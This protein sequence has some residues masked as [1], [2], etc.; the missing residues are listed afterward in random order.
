MADLESNDRYKNSAIRKKRIHHPMPEKKVTKIKQ[1]VSSIRRKT[2]SGTTAIVRRTQVGALRTKQSA[3]IAHYQVA[4]RPHNYLMKKWQWYARWHNWK[5]YSLINIFI[6]IVS[7]FVISFLSFRAF[8]SPSDTKVWTF[9]SPSDYAFNSN[10]IESNNNNLRLKLQDAVSNFTV[11][12]GQLQSNNVLDVTADSTYYYVA[13]DLGIDVIRQDTWVRTAYITSGGGF[14]TLAVANDYIY[15]GKNGGIYRWQ[16]STL[17][18]NTALGSVRYSTSTTPALGNQN[19][20]RLNVNIIASK[21]YI[22]VSTPTYAHIIKDEQGSVSIVKASIAGGY[23]NNGAVLS[24]DGALYYDMRTNGSSLTDGAILVK[25][26]AITMTS[27]WTGWTAAS[28]DYGTDWAPLHGPNPSRSFFTGLKVTTGTSTSNSGNNTIYVETEDGL[29]IIQENRTT[30]GSSTITN[31]TN[32]SRGSNLLSGATA[33]GRFGS[34]VS[35]N[36]TFDGNSGSYYISTQTSAE[37]WV[38]YDLGLPKTF[39]FMRQYFW[40]NAIYTPSSYVIESSTQGTSTNLAPTATGW[41]PWAQSG[42]PATG[43]LDNNYNSMYYSAFNSGAM[44]QLFEQSYA[45]PQSISGVDL[46]YW[47]QNTVAKNYQIEGSSTVTTSIT[48]S[49]ATSSST[50]NNTPASYGPLLAIDRN[51]GTR[52]ISNVATNTAPQW[53]QLD[54]GTA[55]SI[56]GLAWVN[57]SGYTTKDF[58][59]DYSSDG[60]N[61][62]S[63][64]ST[65]NNSLQSNRIK[66]SSPVTGRYI[67][68]YV[69]QSGNGA[70]TSSV[71]ISEIEPFSSMFEEGTVNTLATVS[72]NSSLGK[73]SSFTP[74]TVKSIR[75]KATSTYAAN[76]QMGIREMKTYQTTFDGGTVNQ[77]SSVSGLNIPIIWGNNV[78]HDVSFAN[79]TSRYLRIRYTGY[80]NGNLL[81]SEVELNNTSLPEY[82][83]S[84]IKGS[85][86]DTQNGRYYSVHNSS[87]AEDGRI[88]RIDGVSVNTPVIGEIINTTSKPTLLSNEFSSVKYVDSTKLVVGS[89]AGASFIGQRYAT[90]IPTIEP[91]SAYSPA[92]VASWKTFTESST[93]NGGE[94]YYQLSNDNGANWYY[95]NGVAWASAGTGNYNTAD[96]INTNITNFPI[97]SRDFKWRAYL[98]SNGSQSITLSNITLT[99]NPDVT[100]PSANASNIQMFK[101][102]GGPAIASNAWVNASSPYFNWTD[103]VDDSNPG[104]TGIKGYCLYLGQNDTANPETSKGILGSSPLDTDGACPYAVSTSQLDLATIGVLDSALIS[105]TSAYYL[106]IKALDYSNNVYSGSPVSFPFRFDNSAPT[107]PGFISGPSQ[108]I[109]TKD[110]TLTW[111]ATGSGSISDTHSGVIGLQYRIGNSSWYGINHNGAEDES[112]LLPNTGSYRTDAI[113]D[114][115]NL[116]EGNNIIYFRSLDA[117]GNFSA[118]YATA[119][120]K[121]NTASPS[122]PLSVIATPST[123]TVNSFA[124][125]WS[126]PATYV[127]PSSALQYCY[128]INTLPTVNTCTYTEAGVTSLLA[129]AY[130]TQ[131]GTNTFYVVAKDEAG[132]INYD[133]YASASFTAN[134][135]AP[136][137]PLDMEIADISTKATSNWKVALS[138][139]P[140]TNTGAGVSSYRVYRSTD[141]QIFNQIATTGGVSY[142]DANLSQQTY[143]YKVRACDSANN[144]GANSATVDMYPTGKFTEPAELV[145]PTTVSNITTKRARITWSTNRES[146]SKIAIGKSRGQYSPSEISNSEQVTS[147]EVNLDNL[148]AGKTY[149]LVSRWTDEDGNTG[150]SDE[151]SFQTS[152]APVLKE[153]NTLKVGLTVATIQ[154]TSKDATKVDVQFGKGEDFGGIKSLNTS[155]KESKYEIELS[156]LDDG[157][158]YFYRIT[159]FDSEGGE[160]KSSIFS[161]TTPPRPRISNL[162][163]QPIVGE[164]TSTQQITWTT[165]VPT[166]TL[167]TYGKENTSGSDIQTPELKTEHEIIVRNLED[168]SKY[169]LFAQ[170]RDEGGNLAVSDKQL[171]RTALDTRAPKISEI[172]L[173]PNIR[174]TGNEAR[175]QVVVS[176]KTDEPATSQI[177][178]AE[179]SAATQFNLRTTEDAELTTEHIVIVSDLPTSKVYTLSPISK[180]KSGNVVK[181]VTK[182]VIIGR[183]SDNVL[184][185]VLSS[186]RKIFGI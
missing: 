111:P 38:E 71:R 91:S 182:P 10:K 177:A 70:D 180:D 92:A 21:V 129:S 82:F 173:E 102:N 45:T 72:N 3:I 97:G 183:A 8:A 76:N 105:S 1:S 73:F 110:V 169:F 149:Y 121:I 40:T 175:G 27:D 126:A 133:T 12:G 13:T 174:G 28:V 178:Y 132:N 57:E 143:Y 112:D 7:L 61:W 16:I 55:Q 124:F 79:T 168:D 19:I 53:L 65:T 44:T 30:P 185:I 20:Q 5:W 14:N 6:L 171:F 145:S 107:A 108:F 2:K 36:Q 115:S 114:Y 52:W 106:H 100:P 90:D 138:W 84:R 184:D 113:Y 29:M 18:N 23:T 122:S 95:W 181:S 56:A 68:L 116:I 141:N 22:A 118:T 136:G 127:G 158:K 48:P 25:Y 131:P 66:F 77:L 39:N 186:L 96:V 139:A 150:V 157:A 99:I 147:H 35:A 15:A 62:T 93:K 101:S 24:D 160:Y 67:R 162:S 54:L 49:T 11:A 81:S 176:W 120:I 166:N 46:Q 125:N 9:N 59:I 130:A 98:V 179:G 140:P 47:D 32:S 33:Q 51:A 50:L 117:A 63:A 60:S 155:A 74:T 163:F 42:Y 43:P 103:G 94:I 37:D 137:L 167:I 146:D 104:A 148:E 109:A 87:A 119:V 34:S 64:Y 83:P 89:G 164:P 153:V 151:I 58:S 170:G 41:A 135:A 172:T 75:I 31:Y 4:Q 17:T 26:N 159:M 85:S 128:T 142:V 134:T 165:N 144:C 86:I 156:G 88:I 161:F 152:P 154:F 69:T 78:S 80:G 123:N